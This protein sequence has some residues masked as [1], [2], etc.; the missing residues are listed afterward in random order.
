MTFQPEL[1]TYPLLKQTTLPTILQVNYG[2][3]TEISYAKLDAFLHSFS[4]AQQKAIIAASID[5]LWFH[6]QPGAN[7]R[8][9]LQVYH[10]Q[11]YRLLGQ[12]TLSQSFY[13]LVTQA[14]L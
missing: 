3:L 9:V 4:L 8:M 6:I 1:S 2:T 13:L 11:I 10:I 5:R 12:N 14:D 7:C